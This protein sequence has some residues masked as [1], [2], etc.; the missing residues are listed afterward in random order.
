M[1]LTSFEIT[2]NR[3]EPKKKSP[4]IDI[5]L[6][7]FPDNLVKLIGGLLDEKN[8]PEKHESR[9]ILVRMDK[10]IIPFMHK[11]LAT[12]NNLLRHEVVKIIELIADKRSIPLQIELLEDP[13]PDI[14]WIAAEGLIN[15]G[16]RSILPLLKSLRDGKNPNFIRKG[17]HHV[18][19]SLMNE[20]EK[21]KYQTLLLCLNDYHELGGTVP[22][23]AS[24]AIKSTFR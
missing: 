17:A 21:E 16:R 14:R 7:D 2:C 4:E 13:E 23:E 24:R 20:H 11:L 15:S 12:K 1:Q 5:N 8:Y 3:M 19:N 18:L 9:D 6:S 22:V 10:K